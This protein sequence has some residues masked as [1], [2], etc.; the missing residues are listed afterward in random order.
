MNPKK[1]IVF[2]SGAS[3]GIGRSCGTLLHQRGYYVIGTSR[4]P[5]SIQDTSFPLIEMDVR[6]EDSVQGAFGKV[7]K[8]LRFRK[9][10]FEKG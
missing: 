3:K 9:S 8:K 5:D 7:L 4:N 6:D 1:G 2:I 10:V